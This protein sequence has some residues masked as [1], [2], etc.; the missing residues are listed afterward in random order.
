MTAPRTLSY[1]THADQ[2]GDLYTAKDPGA[3]VLMLLH[4]GFWRMP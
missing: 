2:V 3:R 4:G 1:G